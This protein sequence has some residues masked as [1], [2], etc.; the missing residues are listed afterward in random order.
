M[1]DA[2]EV[3]V[4]VTRGGR[5]PL[6]VASTCS[7]AEEFTDPVTPMPTWAEVALVVRKNTTRM[8]RCLL[9]WSVS[10]EI[11]FVDFLSFIIHP[12]TNQY[13]YLGFRSCICQ[14]MNQFKRDN[15]NMSHLFHSSVMEN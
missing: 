15:R 2:S 8:C 5:K 14:R 4:S 11:L 6:F 9:I 3:P 12:L 1:V 13:R 10:F 7:F